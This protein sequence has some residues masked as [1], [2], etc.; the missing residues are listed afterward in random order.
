MI[1]LLQTLQVMC[2]QIL[3]KKEPCFL[4]QIFGNNLQHFTSIF[5]T[6]LCLLIALNL[7]IHFL[8]FILKLLNFDIF[9]I[10]KWLEFIILLWIFV[11]SPIG[12]NLAQLIGLG[13]QRDSVWVK[14]LANL[15]PLRCGQVHL[16]KTLLQLVKA[17]WADPVLWL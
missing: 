11:E 14:G 10:Q 4:R 7:F 2:V 3:C 5:N 6:H 8:I 17:D 15:R 9:L 12:G 1:K 16:R 13:F